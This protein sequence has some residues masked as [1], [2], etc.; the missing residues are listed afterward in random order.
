M[1]FFRN[2]GIPLLDIA[3]REHSDEQYNL[4]N[5]DQVK[6]IL[7]SDKF[8]YVFQILLLILLPVLAAAGLILKPEAGGKLIVHLIWGI[9]WPLMICL[10][11]LFGRIWCM[12]CPL[13]FL[14]RMAEKA[15]SLLHIRQRNLSRN[16]KRGAAVLVLYVLVQMLDAAADIHKDPTATAY[17]ILGLLGISGLAGLFFKNGA[18][19]KGFCPVSLTLGTYSRGGMISF[20]AGSENACRECVSKSCVREC[21]G[22]VSP[23]KLKSNKDCL[24]CARC[25]KVC[26][27]DN[28]Q[29]LFRKPFD[30]RNRREIMASWIVTL[31]VM[32]DSGFV[33][34][35]LAEDWKA[36]DSIF[37]ALPEKAGELT[38]LQNYA[39]IFEGIWALILFP[40]LFWTMLGV[41]L[42]LSNGALGITKAWRKLALPAVIIF[43][44]GHM[45]K[46]IITLVSQIHLPLFNTMF[47]TVSGFIILSAAL[48]FSVREDLIVRGIHYR[49]KLIPHI[50]VY[51][52]LAVLII[53]T[54]LFPG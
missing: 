16:L 41:I 26:N 11:V 42:K 25:T 44:A 36:A 7:L 49:K 54:G 32:A 23:P 28:I 15:G 46:C 10:T 19:C 48:Y 4:L 34:G 21:P 30:I 3:E 47:L 40:L 39:G 27:R 18:L 35:E 22:F 6:K 45:V 52:L 17:F 5:I 12:I 31:F 50:V 20:R 37:M 38:Q 1:N 8:P 13:E 29:L 24:L 9:W 53:G 43:S 33:I 2:E 51:L 14:G